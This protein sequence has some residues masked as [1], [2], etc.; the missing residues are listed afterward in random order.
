MQDFLDDYKTCNLQIV[1]V[2]EKIC[3]TPMIRLTQNYAYD[4]IELVREMN[5]YRNEIIEKIITYYQEII[6]YLIVVFEGFESHI[7]MVTS[8]TISKKLI[9][10]KIFF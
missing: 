10:N 1:T 8:I 3:D 7:Q 2:C 5:K 9:L 4:L 6:Q